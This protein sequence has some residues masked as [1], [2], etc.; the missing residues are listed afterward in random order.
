MKACS[1][2]FGLRI[3]THAYFFAIQL[4]ALNPLKLSRLNYFKVVRPM[5]PSPCKIRRMHPFFFGK[6]G[7][8]PVTS[9][10]FILYSER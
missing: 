10:N 3:I 1:K 8:L 9:K 6:T 2:R 5:Q 7:G 4:N